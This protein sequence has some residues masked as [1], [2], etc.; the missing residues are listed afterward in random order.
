MFL[1]MIT[2]IKQRHINIRINGKGLKKINIKNQGYYFLKIDKNLHQGI[3][4][5]NIGYIMTKKIVI[6]KISQ[7]ESI[8][9]NN[10]FCYRSI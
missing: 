4:V 10:I 5:Y 9:F 6:A 2:P 8:A 3:D 1:N 7:H